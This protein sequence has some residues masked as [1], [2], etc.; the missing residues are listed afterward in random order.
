MPVVDHYRQQ[1]KVEEVSF[2]LFIARAHV[3]LCLITRRTRSE[4]VELMCQIDSSPGVDEVYAQ[5]RRVLDQ[6][7]TAPTA[8]PVA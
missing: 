1:N 2:E 5:V 8:A 4:R 6:R 3:A 7:L